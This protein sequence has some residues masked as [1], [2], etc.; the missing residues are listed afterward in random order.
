M[1][2]RCTP[3]SWAIATSIPSSIW[4]S[5]PAP[6][7]SACEGTTKPAFTLQRG[8]ANIRR[9]SA[10]GTRNGNSRKL[11]RPCVVPGAGG[12]E[13]Y[14]L[15]DH[16]I[17]GRPASAAPPNASAELAR[18]YLAAFGAAT[19]ADF[20]TWSGLAIGAARAA[21]DAIADELTEVTTSAG[22]SWILSRSANGPSRATPLRLVGGF[23][24]FLLGYA[25]RSLHVSPTDA[26]RINAGGGIIRPAVVADGRVIGTWACRRQRGDRIDVDPFRPFTTDE[27]SA[28]ER[29]A[30]DVGRFLGTD[31]ALTV[32]GR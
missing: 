7:L 20:A 26:R 17:G 12:K 3:P 2:R 32:T 5:T 30:A 8:C 27:R 23:D 11:T 21:W 16:W 15:L 10:S 29:E 13:R 4:P 6:F 25:D 22:P 19:P 24:T 31:P 14:A 1:G 18:R 9:S 28:L